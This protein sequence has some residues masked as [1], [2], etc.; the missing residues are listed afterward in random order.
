MKRRNF[1]GC[2]V[3]GGLGTVLA[4]SIKN[5]VPET[6][7]LQPPFRLGTTYTAEYEKFLEFFKIFNGFE[8]NEKQKY[9]SY[10]YF[11][12]TVHPNKLFIWPR[13]LGNSTLMVTLMTFEACFNKKQIV[14]IC[15]RFNESYRL[16]DYIREAFFH[17]MMTGIE[18]IDRV[19]GNGILPGCAFTLTAQPGGGKTTLMLQIFEALARQGYKVGYA[20]GEENRYQ[21]A[22]N[23][24][25]L[26]VKELP[27]ANQT[28]FDYIRD[29]AFSKHLCLSLILCDDM[30]FE[31]S[32]GEKVSGKIRF[33]YEP[34]LSSSY[35][36]P[37]RDADLIFRNID[38]ERNSFTDA[39]FSA[40]A[41]SFVYGTAVRLRMAV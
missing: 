6:G 39:S 36:L 30:R 5:K 17:R 34:S 37:L 7:S 8:V 35:L 24:R 25:R 19:F 13:Q 22:F 29:R 15:D 31:Y 28:E 33:L 14:H 3:L 2:S 26:G 9:A 21:L 11:T 12:N 18:E 4:P 1:I 41:E 27:I 10:C 20:S 32:C 16:F 38:G 40:A 23:C